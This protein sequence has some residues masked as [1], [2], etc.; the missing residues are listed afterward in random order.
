M[1]GPTEKIRSAAEDRG[2]LRLVEGV[3]PDPEVMQSLGPAIS[4]AVATRAAFIPF[5]TP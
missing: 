5:P 3:D 4:A 2:Q 1:R